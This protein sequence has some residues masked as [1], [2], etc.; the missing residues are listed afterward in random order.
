MRGMAGCSRRASRRHL[1]L[2]LGY[3]RARAPLKRGVSQRFWVLCG[4]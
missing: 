1:A 4:W 2:D 3:T